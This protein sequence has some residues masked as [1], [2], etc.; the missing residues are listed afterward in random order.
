MNV[1]A[2]VGN[3]PW[4]YDIKCFVQSREYPPQA[5]ENEKKYIRRMAFQFFLS[6]EILYKRTHEATL[7]RCV[8]AEEANL[9]I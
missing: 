8:D 3:R 9:L 7:L 4:Y 5:T 2:E 1:E 6:E